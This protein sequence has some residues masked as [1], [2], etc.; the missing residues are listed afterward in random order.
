MNKLVAACALGCAL[1]LGVAGTAGAKPGAAAVAGPITWG[2]ADDT[3]KYADDGGTWFNQQLLAGG[4]T[5]VRWTLSWSRARP[6]TIDELPFLER[7][8]PQAQKDGIKV[9]LALY[10]RPAAAHDA[11]AFCDW[12][13]LVA[14]TVAAWGIHDYIVWNEPNT[15]L[16]WSPQTDSTPADYVELLSR[17]YDKLH[18]ADPLAN[19]I[20]F[21][22]SPRKGTAT[23]TAPIPFLKAAGEAYRKSGRTTPIMD[24]LSVHPYPNPNNPTD[25]PDVGYA[26]EDFY[27]IPNLDR[28]KK[29]VYE[30]WNGTGQPT[31]VN[32]LLL[33]IDE[34][35]WQTDTTKYSQYVNDENVSTV[36]EA[37]QVQYHQR[38]IQ[39]YFACDADIATVNWFLLVDEPYR[40]GRDAKGNVLGG[41]WQSG[42]LTAGGE[43]V[44]TAKPA[45]AALT[46]LHNQGRGACTGPQIDWKPASAAGG[47]KGDGGGTG[48]GGETTLDV[49]G[50]VS[51]MGEDAAGDVQDALALFDTQPLASGLLVTNLIPLVNLFMNQV[52]TAMGRFQGL[53]I[54]DGAVVW[55][56]GSTA[57]TGAL[58]QQL[59]WGAS[60]RVLG[61]ARAAK[62]LVIARGSATVKGGKKL[63]LR[64][65]AASKAAL[66]P[67]SVYA[68]IRVRDAADRSHVG[69]VIKRLAV[70]K[71]SPACKKG[72]KPTAKKPCRTP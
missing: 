41:G 23:Q 17:C 11:V 2:V 25:G 42:L 6:D 35:G 39:Q 29:A 66:G 49:D 1:I 62:G 9:E 36:S 71:A 16:Y 63:K 64:L 33:V 27:G 14:T 53:A 10:G 31:T 18:G 68:A 65:K 67:G 37:Q 7:A 15:A 72:K 22:L 61:H 28:I 51:I 12:A 19:V 24:Q 50:L 48:A 26:N 8:A 52:Q 47:S 46:P 38:T 32:G 58:L 54:V 34:V 20:G 70:V 45:Y 55:V 56:P 21:G 57:S 5:E 13:E 44:S 69:Y 59:G 3:G 30:A 40:D 4:M 60:T 43:N